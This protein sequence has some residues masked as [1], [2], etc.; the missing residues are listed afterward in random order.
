MS[1]ELREALMVIAH[2]KPEPVDYTA[3]DIDD[4]AA[5]LYTDFLATV[6]VARKAL[7]LKPLKAESC[8]E[9]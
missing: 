2:S 8:D 3:S 1:D 7:K 5:E 9:E 4:I 6:N